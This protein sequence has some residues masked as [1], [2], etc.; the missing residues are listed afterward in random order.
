MSA[1]PPVA[2]RASE[3]RV[4]RLGRPG[5]ARHPLEPGIAPQHAALTAAGAEAADD[6]PRRQAGGAAGAGRA[7]EHVLRAPEALVREHVVQVAGTVSLQRGEELALDLAGQ[8]GTG[9]RRRDVELV[10]LRQA[11]AH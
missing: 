8:V 3:Q 9:L 10:R 7:V 2:W 1:M 5:A 11:V 6:D 4:L